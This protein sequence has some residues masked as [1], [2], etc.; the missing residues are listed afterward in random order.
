MKKLKNKIKNNKVLS[1]CYKVG[2]FIAGFILTIILIV[3]LVQK[4]SN[5]K[6]AIGGYR[7]FN[8]AT[9]S[10]KGEYDIGDIII[11][12]KTAAE[13]LK[14]G[15]NVTYIG[16]SRVESSSCRKNESVSGFTVTNA[17]GR[18]DTSL[19]LSSRSHD[20]TRVMAIAK[21]ITDSFVVSFLFIL[22]IVLICCLPIKL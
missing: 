18:K 20:E 12:E 11:I 21:R 9:G 1:I 4:F 19:S 8:V 2:K 13:D 14:I 5:N 10:M 16:K 15:D 3:I 6:I 7:V 22:L 17:V